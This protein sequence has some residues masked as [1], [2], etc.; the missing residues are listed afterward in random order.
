MSKMM[1][2]DKKKLMQLGE[3]NRNFVEKIYNIEKIVDKWLTIY[4]KQ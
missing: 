3:N 2:Y 1:N 4:F